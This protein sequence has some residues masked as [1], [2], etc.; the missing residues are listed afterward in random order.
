MKDG[1]Y[2]ILDYDVI[3]Q[4]VKKLNMFDTIKVSHINEEYYTLCNENTVWEN[5]YNKLFDRRIIT[6][7]SVHKGPMNW[8]NCKCCP[9]P[10]YSRI[11]H[12]IVDSEYTCK[13]IDHYTNIGY[14]QIKRKFKNYKERCKNKYIS[15]VLKDN[16]IMNLRYS[17]TQ[18]NYLINKKK[19]IERQMAHR[20]S[21]ID[22][23][24]SILKGF[25]IQE[26]TQ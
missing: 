4:I 15:M 8:M 13:K 6:S 25:G 22:L 11:Y 3:T 24:Q 18:M 2:N 21:E 20:Q 26:D 9:Y 10:G 19:N 16:Y 12:E 1:V 23:Y 7:T 17:S 14:K 5:H